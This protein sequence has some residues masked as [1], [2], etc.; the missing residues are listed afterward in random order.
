[1]TLPPQKAVV[2]VAAA[3]VA[4][5][6]PVAAVVVLLRAVTVAAGSAERDIGLLSKKRQSHAHCTVNR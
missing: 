4:M 5:V 2:A 3:V 1:M 6:A